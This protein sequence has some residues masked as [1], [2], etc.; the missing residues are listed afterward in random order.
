MKY[1]CKKSF[2]IPKSDDDGFLTDETVNIEPGSMWE[3]DESGFRMLGDVDH[4]R[5]ENTENFSWLEIDRETL[6]EHFEKCD[7]GMRI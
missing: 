5:L 3:E 7:E 6:N 4:I 1:K 2:S